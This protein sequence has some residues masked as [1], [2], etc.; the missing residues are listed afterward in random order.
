MDKKNFPALFRFGSHFCLHQT[1]YFDI[2]FKISKMESK[3]V[4][5]SS[6]SSSSSGEEH[7]DSLS[8][9]IAVVQPV[10]QTKSTVPTEILQ[11]SSTSHEINPDESMP[12]PQPT[13]ETDVDIYEVPTELEYSQPEVII[14]SSDSD[15]I[16]YHT[17]TTVGEYP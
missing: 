13:E 1:N 3:L 14:L 9:K 12:S 17:D 6:T 10:Q 4:D 2:F 8:K 11:E 5:Y 15:T 7:K 16:S